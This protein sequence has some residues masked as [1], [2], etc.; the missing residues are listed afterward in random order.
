M[1]SSNAKLFFIGKA[2]W[3]DF[4]GSKITGVVVKPYFEPRNQDYLES[5]SNAVFCKNAV[6]KEGRHD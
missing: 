1:K 4:L 6:H 3:E 5:N 2:I